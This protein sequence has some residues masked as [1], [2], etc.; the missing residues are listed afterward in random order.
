MDIPL[1][2]KT[3]HILKN[4]NGIE[5]SQSDISD[6]GDS[7]YVLKENKALTKYLVDQTI[8][9]LWIPSYAKA[10]EVY[11]VEVFLTDETN[12]YIMRAKSE[13]VID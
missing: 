2:I 3:R 7:N 1:S 6:I 8:V 11:T 4:P 12:E 5:V 13:I 10:G 9:P